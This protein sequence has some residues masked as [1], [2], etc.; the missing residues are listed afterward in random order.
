LEGRQPRKGRA[1]LRTNKGYTSL[2]LYQVSPYLDFEPYS[3]P[4]NGCEEVFNPKPT[5]E[6][7]AILYDK[8][9]EYINRHNTL[10]L[11][12]GWQ[13]FGDYK[14]FILKNK[15]DQEIAEAVLDPRISPLLMTF[16]W[17]ADL[18]YWKPNQL[19]MTIPVVNACRYDDDAPAHDQKICDDVERHLE[20]DET[21][22]REEWLESRPVAM[23][24]FGKQDGRCNYFTRRYFRWR[25]E[26][27][28]TDELND[29]TRKWLNMDPFIFANRERVSEPGAIHK[30]GVIP[31]RSIIGQQNPPDYDAFLETWNKAAHDNLTV[32]DQLTSG[33]I[34]FSDLSDMQTALPFEDQILLRLKSKFVISLR[35]DAAHSQRTWEGLY[36]GSLAIHDMSERLYS[37]LTPLPYSLPWRLMGI[38]SNELV[39]FLQK[40]YLLFSTWA[41]M[42]LSI[43]DHEKTQA[44]FKLF[45]PLLGLINSDDISIMLKAIRKYRK[46][47]LWNVENSEL[48]ENLLFE[49]A[50]MMFKNKDYHDTADKFNI[51]LNWFET[52]FPKSCLLDDGQ[53][54]YEAVYHM[55]Y[56]NPERLSRL[57]EIIE[58]AEHYK[59]NEGWLCGD[60]DDGLLA[61]LAGKIVGW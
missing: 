56:T 1:L 36:F 60:W 46:Q 49:A 43:P 15:S 34:W 48:A 25:I 12:G 19:S 54:P 42:A 10:W 7:M 45:E 41:K 17:R 35:G 24:Y 51:D 52:N 8:Y 4:L 39:E 27:L 14:D 31:A 32:K 50:R 13:N 26:D 55:D 58:E 29:N 33:V 53:S 2:Q 18:R 3:N 30:T 47:V 40:E 44:F 11:M 23:S 57:K 16:Q 61:N 6:L 9:S 5:H 28:V 38:F 20:R 37:F 22:T 21:L 59:N